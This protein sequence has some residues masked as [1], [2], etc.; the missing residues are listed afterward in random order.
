MTHKRLTGPVKKVDLHLPLDVWRPEWCGEEQDTDPHER[1]ASLLLNTSHFK[2]WGCRYPA[3]HRLTT[4]LRTW[5]GSAK[6]HVTYAAAAHWA[7]KMA[8]MRRDF[9]LAASP[10]VKFWDDVVD[11][12]LMVLC[13][14]R[15][16]VVGA[17][18]E[19]AASR[20]EPAQWDFVARDHD[21]NVEEGSKAGA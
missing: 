4:R 14:K 1:G 17:W 16:I 15:R 12:D 20:S 8:C 18:L 2:F 6:R 19:A 21:D 13:N 11:A 7:L 10:N 3:R 9:W 5:I